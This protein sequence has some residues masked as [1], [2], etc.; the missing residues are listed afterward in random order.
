MKRPGQG[1]CQIDYMALYD[2]ISFIELLIL[3]IS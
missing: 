2:E 3:P 1:G